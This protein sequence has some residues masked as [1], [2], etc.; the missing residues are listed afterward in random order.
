M[1]QFA[2]RFVEG[3][4][5]ANRQKPSGI[6]AKETILRIH[7]VPLL[8]TRTLDAITPEDVQRLK[9]ALMHRSP[10][11]VNN[12]LTTLSVLL[13]TAV[14]WGVIEQMPCSMRL[15]PVPKSSAGFHEFDEY[16][17]LVAAARII[18]P[19]AHV[20]VLLGG[21]AGLRCGEMM[22]LEWAD[23]DLGKRQLRGT[24]QQRRAAAYDTCR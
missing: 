9:H 20:A 12:V 2:P 23:V 5:R 11:T 3:Y 14:E 7:L 16:E 24:S 21:D 6:A 18:D 1:E 19:R 17:R 22:A 10:K 8:G 15:L 13:K 4:A